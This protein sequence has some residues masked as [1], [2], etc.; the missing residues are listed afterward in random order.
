MQ[1]GAFCIRVFRLR[2]FRMSRCYRRDVQVPRGW[3]VRVK[4]LGDHFSHWV[5]AVVE[6]GSGVRLGSSTREFD[7]GVRFGSSIRE[8]DSGVRLGGWF[9]FICSGFVVKRLRG[10]TA[11]FHQGNLAETRRICQLLSEI[12][13]RVTK[14][15]DHF[16]CMQRN[17]LC[18][19][20]NP[21]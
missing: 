16:I 12:G 3:V 18:R 7:S 19:G 15:W 20:G 4:A 8:F 13:A 1:L 11:S 10:E 21:E 5:T 6:F 17:G 14:C 9:G 2:R